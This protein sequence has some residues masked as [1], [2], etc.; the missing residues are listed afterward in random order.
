MRKMQMHL[1]NDGHLINSDLRVVKKILYA[2]YPYP[3]Y[4]H[5]H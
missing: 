3:K 5:S 1:E 4:E 2:M